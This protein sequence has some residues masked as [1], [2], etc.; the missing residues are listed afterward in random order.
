MD[1]FLTEEQ[2]M[3]QEVARNIARERVMPRA[4]ELDEKE[5]FP[6]DLIKEI[7]RADLF[8]V[9][10][11]EAYGGLGGNVM[12]LCL[13]TEELSRACSGVAVSYAASALGAFPVLL[14]GTE[15]QKKNICRRSPPV[16]SL[17]PSD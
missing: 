9:F 17:P 8:G 1:Y 10:I 16:K 5:E 12:E 4:A 6:W 7:A 2:L 11:P 13:A 14:S 3:V 15:E